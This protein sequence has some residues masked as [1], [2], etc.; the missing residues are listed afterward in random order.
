MKY[1]TVKLT[2]DQANYLKNLVVEDTLQMRKQVNDEFN[3]YLIGFNRRLTTK[4]AKELAK[5]S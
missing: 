2:K 4:L 1:I 3:K 5:I